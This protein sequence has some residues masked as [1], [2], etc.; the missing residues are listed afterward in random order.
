MTTS[1]LDPKLLVHAY[2]DGELN[3][4]EALRVEQMM[5]DDPALA[6]ECDRVRSLQHLLHDRLVPEGRL[7]D[8]APALRR[9]PA[10]V[11]DN[12][13]PRGGHSPPR[14]PLRQSSGA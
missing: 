14:W 10:Y 9:Q 5:A 3:T 13:N 1:D 7:P 12:S 8:C 4:T 6:A 2:V 11:S